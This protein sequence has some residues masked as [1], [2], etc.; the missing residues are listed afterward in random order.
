MPLF[1]YRDDYKRTIKIISAGND[2]ERS[3]PLYISDRNEVVLPPQETACASQNI[4]SFIRPQILPLGPY[5]EGF[6]TGAVYVSVSSS[7]AYRI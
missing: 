1:P 6:K 2:V 3:E 7:T 4:Y 5:R